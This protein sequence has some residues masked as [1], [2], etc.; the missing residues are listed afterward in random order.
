MTARLLVL[1]AV[2][3]L[4]LAVVAIRE[5]RNPAIGR[6]QP[7][8]TVLTGPDCRL[9]PPLLLLLDAA[10]APYRLLDVTLHRIPTAVRALPTVLVAD[11]RGEVALRR[12]GRSALTDLETILAVAAAGGAVRETA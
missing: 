1:L 5:R 11:E 8:I 4:A 10:G 2:F 9:C 3:G 6:I 7:G 12:S